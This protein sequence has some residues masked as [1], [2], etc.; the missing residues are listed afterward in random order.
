MIGWGRSRGG[1]YRWMGQ[2]RRMRSTM[3]EGSV[4][5]RGSPCRRYRVKVERA[6]AKAVAGRRGEVGGGGARPGLT[7]TSASRRFSPHLMR[8]ESHTRNHSIGGST[9]TSLVKD[10]LPESQYTSRLKDLELLLNSTQGDVV[11]FNLLKE[12]EMME[13][14]E[15]MSHENID[16]LMDGTMTTAGGETV[17]PADVDNDPP[18]VQHCNL[19][20]PTVTKSM[21]VAST[22]WGH[23]QAS[24]ASSRIARDT[25][26][27]LE[28]AQHHK[29]RQNLEKINGQ[30]VESGLSKSQRLRLCPKVATVAAA[31]EVTRSPPS[32]TTDPE[33]VCE[34]DYRIYSNLAGTY[35]SDAAKPSAECMLRCIGASSTDDF[36]IE[37]M[38]N[39]RDEEEIINFCASYWSSGGA[40]DPETSESLTYRLN[41][42]IC[43]V[44]V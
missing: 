21:K 37:T 40:D 15:L 42:D 4:A 2:M 13:D 33:S 20:F 26:P 43:V 30:V 22:K 14:D 1:G 25:R 3:G 36:P 31:E 32:T 17:K 39:T 6:K 11:G 19:D 38:E 9:P 44:E 29:K 16:N 27:I 34:R 35:V 18:I 41:S 5:C 24:R 10:Q 23:V 12:M 8:S 28:E 7:C